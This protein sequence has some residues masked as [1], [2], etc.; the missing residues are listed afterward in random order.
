MNSWMGSRLMETQYQ[1]PGYRT[2]LREI[3]IA[4]APAPAGL[5]VMTEEHEAT[6]DDGWFTVNMNDNR[7]FESLPAMR[8]RR[9]YALNFADGHA[10][11]VKLRDIATQVGTQVTARNPDWLRLKQMTTVP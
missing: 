6:L 9:S 3:E 1:Q 8:H 4:A 7:P 11:A 5:W 10:T 2:F